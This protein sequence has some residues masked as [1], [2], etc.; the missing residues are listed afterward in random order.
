MLGAGVHE[1]T[2]NPLPAALMGGP[3]TACTCHTL[4]L[5]KGQLV[6][7]GL[8]GGPLAPL[9]QLQLFLEQPTLAGGVGGKSR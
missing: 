3:A 2:T 9:H 5:F 8:D 4:H 1:Q 6:L 7:D